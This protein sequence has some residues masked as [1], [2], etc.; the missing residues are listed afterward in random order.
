MSTLSAHH[1]WEIWLT[2]VSFY[3]LHSY[4]SVLSHPRSMVDHIMYNNLVGLQ[5]SVFDSSSTVSFI[6]NLRLTNQIVFSLPLGRRGIL[7]YFPSLGTYPFFSI[8]PTGTIYDIFIFF[9]DLSK[10]MYLSTHIPRK[11][12]IKSLTPHI[13]PE[14]NCSSFSI[15]ALLK[16]SID[17]NV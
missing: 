7:N 16:F 1:R 2:R 8:S 6:Q 3:H 5:L 13:H 15:A 10:Y 9:T 11:K 12:K 4:C 17:L 14:G